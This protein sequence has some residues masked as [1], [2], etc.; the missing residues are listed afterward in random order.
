M[1]PKKSKNKSP[2]SK[3]EVDSLPRLG[4]AREYFLRSVDYVSS[5]TYHSAEIEIGAILLVDPVTKK[6]V[7]RFAWK[8]AGTNDTITA[9]NAFSISDNLE[10]LLADF[11]GEQPFKFQLNCFGNDRTRQA[12][13]ISNRSAISKELPDPARSSFGRTTLLLIALSKMRE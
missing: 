1:F 5:I 13:L 7:V 3:S 12:E 6:D 4:A 2:S 10:K 8:Y 11:P 9:S